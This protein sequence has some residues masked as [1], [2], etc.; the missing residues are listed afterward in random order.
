MYFYSTHVPFLTFRKDGK[1][2]AALLRAVSQ[3]WS[4]VNA[5]H[6]RNQKLSFNSGAWALLLLLGR[7]PGRHDRLLRRGQQDHLHRLLKVQQRR[8]AFLVISISL[9]RGILFFVASSLSLC[10]A[11]CTVQCFVHA[12]ICLCTLECTHCLLWNESKSAYI[13]LRLPR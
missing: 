11:Y 4:A 12:N 6:L 13:F 1:K 7:Q 2:L 9:S 8:G 3:V 10:S 5:Y